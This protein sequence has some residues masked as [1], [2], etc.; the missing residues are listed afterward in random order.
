VLAIVGV[1]VAQ[2]SPAWGAFDGRDDSWEGTSEFVRLAA[3]R[4]G[5]DR[6]R[7]TDV[8][9]WAALRPEDSVILL[10]PLRDLDFFEVSAFLR[11]GGR[12]ALLDD[13]GRGTSLLARFRIRR[14]PP[15]RRPRRAL[16]GDP[17]LAIA[18][19]SFQVV[20]GQ[21]QGRHPIVARVDLVVT[22]HPTGL[23]HPDLTPV[24]TIPSEDEGDVP[25]AVT[26][27][28][29]ERGR[30]FAM[31]DPSALINLMLRYP[32]NRALAE[33][34]VDYLAE[35]DTW[36]ARGGNLYLLANAFEERRSRGSA[37]GLVRDLDDHLA[38]LR[39]RLARAHDDGL[40]GLA[41]LLL[42]VL[43]ALGIVSWALGAA[44]RPY[45]P[46]TPRYA[47]EP[48]L[49]AQGGAAGRVALLTAPTTH[50]ALALLEL[51][52]ALLER[53]AQRLG[54]DPPLTWSEVLAEIDR[55]GALAQPSSLRLRRLVEEVRKLE[56][57][58]ATSRP[59]RA[60]DRM[61]QRMRESV[62]SILQ[63]VGERRGG[64]R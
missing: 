24:L 63:E 38:A 30:L 56:A 16:R 28:I 48:P 62:E 61:V 53:L 47:R 6:V 40:P 25:L 27:I 57:S 13:Y 9:D 42:A 8:L 37:A 52:N 39:E 49:V 14:V 19:P 51:G 26:G 11:G 2:A 44:T 33:G 18:V 50:R 31:G 46:A 55:Q 4:L 54:V 1:L 5:E 23:D 45:R 7:V 59:V 12:L 58:V 60:N 20:A 32:G 41:T 36:G 34:L 35:D 22:N 10:H 43:A 15:P 64:T 29:A 3:A 17:D 21:E